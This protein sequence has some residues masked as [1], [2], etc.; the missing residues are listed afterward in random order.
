MFEQ[1]N[2]LNQN[3]NLY[4]Y[5][6][7]ETNH[8]ATTELKKRKEVKLVTSDLIVLNSPSQMLEKT[9]RATHMLNIYMSFALI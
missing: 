1:E 3:N 6:L 9:N 7:Y 4:K 5:N 2:L 8:H